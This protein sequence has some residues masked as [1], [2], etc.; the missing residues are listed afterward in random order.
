[1]MGGWS[2]FFF[3]SLLVF[4]RS[5]GVFSVTATGARPCLDALCLPEARSLPCFPLSRTFSDDVRM[6]SVLSR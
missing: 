6:R 3:F 5:L 2:S 1:M 4:A